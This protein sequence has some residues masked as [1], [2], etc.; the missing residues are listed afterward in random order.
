MS[1]AQPEKV[2]EVKPE[3]KDEF[4]ELFDLA[5]ANLKAKPQAPKK[6]TPF[7]EEFFPPTSS[8]TNAA[9]ELFG[10]GNSKPKSNP[11]PVE[12]IPEL[13][14]QPVKPRVEPPKTSKFVMIAND[15]IGGGNNANNNIFD[16]FL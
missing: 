1:S 7:D 10:A 15:I 14:A 16:L 3:V 6:A 13:M 12:M 8:S 9:S 5:N 4:T 11:K 2:P